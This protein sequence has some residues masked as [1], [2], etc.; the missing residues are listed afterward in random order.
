[1]RDT[2]LDKAIKGLLTIAAILLAVGAAAMVVDGLSL[3]RDIF[4]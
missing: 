4:Y 3:I 1:M 2:I